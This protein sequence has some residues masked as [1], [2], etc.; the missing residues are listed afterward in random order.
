MRNL[1]VSRVLPVLD[2][3]A[4]STEGAT[5]ILPIALSII[6][7]CTSAFAFG[8][9]LSHNFV[10][11]AEARREWL[12]LFAT[13]FPTDQSSFW[14]R[15][16]PMLTKYLCILG[17]PLVSKDMA[18]ARYKFEAWALPK[19]DDAEEV[20]KKRDLGQTIEAG[21]L[22]VLYDAV[23]TSMLN[24]QMGAG[25]TGFTMTEAQRRELASECLDHIGKLTYRNLHNILKL[26]TLATLQP[27]LLKHLEPSSHI[28]SMNSRIIRTFSRSSGMNYGPLKTR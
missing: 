13:A 12:N 20:L 25:K 15:E 26:S 28:W 21:R 22:P 6:L 14:L 17:I 3:I 16:Y 19:V 10:V 4:A 27:S 5:S 11:D 2:S 23:R 9:P 1:M 24:L 7:D 18:P 8:I